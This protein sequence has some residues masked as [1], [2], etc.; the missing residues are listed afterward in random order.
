M[1]S[2]VITALPPSRPIWRN[3]LWLIALLAV[4]AALRFY[5][6]EASSLWSDEGNTYVLIQRS[7][8]EIATIGC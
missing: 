2:S 5:A 1:T 8:A 4:A 3:A 7:F 6:L